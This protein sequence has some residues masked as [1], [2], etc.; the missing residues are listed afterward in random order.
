MASERLFRKSPVWADVTQPSL[1]LSSLVGGGPTA[2]PTLL[3]HISN[4]NAF[5]HGAVCLLPLCPGDRSS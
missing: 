4:W 5:A 2:V 1:G 3:S